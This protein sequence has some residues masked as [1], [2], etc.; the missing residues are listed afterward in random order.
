MFNIYICIFKGI[1][2]D[3]VKKL[4]VSSRQPPGTTMDFRGKAAD[5]PGKISALESKAWRPNGQTPSRKLGKSGDIYHII[6]HHIYIY[7]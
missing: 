4:P 5:L 1:P 2:K 3:E 6:S 7:T